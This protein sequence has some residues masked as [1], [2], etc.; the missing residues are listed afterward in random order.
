M[1]RPPEISEDKKGRAD[2]K[3]FHFTFAEKCIL[4]PHCASPQAVT[5]PEILVTNEPF[6]VA[7]PSGLSDADWADINRLRQVYKI[8]GKDAF[9]PGSR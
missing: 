1:R 7:D 4:T 8:D 3:V 6:E 9:V 5:C 2:F